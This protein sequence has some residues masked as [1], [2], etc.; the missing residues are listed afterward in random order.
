MAHFAQEVADDFAGGVR[1]VARLEIT[2]HLGYVIARGEQ[3][4]IHGV[5]GM[6]LSQADR[7]DKSVAN[8][9]PT[10]RLRRHTAF[11]NKSGC[12]SAGQR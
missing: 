5:V 3:G 4:Q 6:H 12:G 9:Q 7:G 10:F 2:R 1:I 11:A 8:A